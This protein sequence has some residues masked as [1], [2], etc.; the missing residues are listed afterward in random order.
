MSQ[1]TEYAARVAGSVGAMMAMVMGVREPAIVARACELGI[2]M[3]LSNIARDVGEDA[4]AGRLYL[5][6]DWLQEAG[7]DP[8]AWLAEPRFDAR[9]GGVVR[10]LLEAAELLY[11]RSEAGIAVLPAGCRPGSGGPAALCG[12]R[13]RSRAPR[14]RFGGRGARVPA[15]RK[16]LLLPRALLAPVPERRAPASCLDE[17]RF[18]VDCLPGGVPAQTEAAV[19]GLWRSLD[20]R[21][22]WLIDL[23]AR[24]ERREQLQRSRS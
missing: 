17:A 23:F 7:I 20:A 1:L 19:E 4:R 6:L 21:A 15:R 14:L 11:R 16:L 12:D 24:L 22:A 8:D 5:P 18:L 10:R 13:P 9:L 2:A 3:Q